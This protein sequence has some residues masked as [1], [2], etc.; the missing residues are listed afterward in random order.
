MI[1]SDILFTFFIFLLGSHMSAYLRF[2]KPAYED[3][4][5]QIRSIKLSWGQYN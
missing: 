3:G 1:Y 2:M 5:R 4:I